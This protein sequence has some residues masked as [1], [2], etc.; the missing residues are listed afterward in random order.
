M[1]NTNYY[2]K[3]LKYKHKYLELKGGVDPAKVCATKKDYRSCNDEKG[4]NYDSGSGKCKF[5]KDKFDSQ[6]REQY[7]KLCPEKKEQNNCKEPCTWNKNNNT[8]FYKDK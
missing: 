4:C 2:E 1:D 3:Y 7:N 5:K 8:C 6:M